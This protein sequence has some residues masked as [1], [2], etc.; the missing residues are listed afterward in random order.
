L[1]IIKKNK[2]IKKIKKIKKK[3]KVVKI[4]LKL[5]EFIIYYRNK[6]YFKNNCLI[7]FKIIVNKINYKRKYNK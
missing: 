1:I 2:K 4:I 7:L 6:K 5:K 3:T